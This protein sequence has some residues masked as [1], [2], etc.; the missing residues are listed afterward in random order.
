MVKRIPQMAFNDE[1]FV[2]LQTI[3]NTSGLSWDRFVA[4]CIRKYGKVDSD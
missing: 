4:M 2:E 3:K 1:E